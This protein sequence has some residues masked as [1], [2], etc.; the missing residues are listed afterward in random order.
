MYS[1]RIPKKDGISAIPPAIETIIGLA[2]GFKASATALALA[3]WPIP[4]PLLVARIIVGLD[5]VASLSISY[6]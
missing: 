4:T 3:K 1:H 6:F 2:M 5:I